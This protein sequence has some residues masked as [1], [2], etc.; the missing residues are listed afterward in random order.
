MLMHGGGARLWRA[1]SILL[2]NLI[3]KHSKRG[4]VYEFV[5]CKSDQI[6]SKQSEYLKTFSLMKGATYVAYVIPTQCRKFHEIN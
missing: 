2:A 6:V 3:K 1:D 5:A 4:T